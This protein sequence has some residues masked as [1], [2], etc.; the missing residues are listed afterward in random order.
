MAY[1]KGLAGAAKLYL[2]S[3]QIFIGRKSNN[4][5][6]LEQIKYEVH[7]LV[8]AVIKFSTAL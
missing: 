8:I 2:N 5:E 4:N 6:A 3:R 7:N 1:V